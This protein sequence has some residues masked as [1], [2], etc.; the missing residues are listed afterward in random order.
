MREYEYRDGN[1]NLNVNNSLVTFLQIR[2]GKPSAVVL[3]G[4]RIEKWQHL[5]SLNCLFNSEPCPL[6]QCPL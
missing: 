6:W 1:L 5:K 2:M 3:E 4:Q